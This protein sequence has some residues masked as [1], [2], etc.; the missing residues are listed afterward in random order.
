MCLVGENGGK[1]KWWGLVF[2]PQANQNEEKTRGQTS[3]EEK[4]KNLCT[5]VCHKFFGLFGF[6]FMYF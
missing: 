4:T 2:S 3:D 6:L 5:W 1:K